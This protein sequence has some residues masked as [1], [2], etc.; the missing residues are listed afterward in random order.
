MKQGVEYLEQAYHTII[1]EEKIFKKDEIFNQ[2]I[3]IYMDNGAYQGV[4]KLYLEEITRRE[5]KDCEQMG[6][7]VLVII[8][9]QREPKRAEKKMY[10]ISDM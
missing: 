8:L 4:E 5:G 10:E 6:L 2:L 3:D 9:I 1:S 7:I